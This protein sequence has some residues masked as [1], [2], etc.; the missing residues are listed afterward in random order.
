[1][2]MSFRSILILLTHVHKNFL[3]I[4]IFQGT[5]PKYI[6]NF[7]RHLKMVAILSM[8]ITHKYIM[9]IIKFWETDFF[10]TT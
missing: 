5:I 10:K 8:I 4:I 6:L 3:D 9:Y 2:W 7:T 1:M